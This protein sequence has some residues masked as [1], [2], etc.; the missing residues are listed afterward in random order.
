MKTIQPPK[1]VLT[2]TRLK[3]T[4]ILLSLVFLGTLAKADVPCQTAISN[5]EDS[6][7]KLQATVEKQA[8]VITELQAEVNT[9]KKNSFTENQTTLMIIFGG[10]AFCI[11]AY[12][13]FVSP[14]SK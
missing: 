7:T 6:V 12:G 2:N 14:N 8:E 11:L 13:M 1:F 3:I 9:K 5:Y 4:I 10:V